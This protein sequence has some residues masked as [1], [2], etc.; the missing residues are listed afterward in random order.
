MS[1][2]YALFCEYYMYIGV[3]ISTLLAYV[4]YCS[5]SFSSIHTH[6]PTHAHTHTHTYYTHAMQ[7]PSVTAATSAQ[8]GAGQDDFNPLADEGVKE[9][10]PEVNDNIVICT[11]L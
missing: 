7:D 5:L 10:E 8:P 6:P 2:I 11:F 9:K 4:P 1:V 3:K